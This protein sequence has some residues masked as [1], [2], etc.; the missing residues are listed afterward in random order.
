MRIRRGFTLIELLV[1]IAIIAVLIAL[2][3]PAVQSAREAARRSQCVNNLKQVGLALH[4]YESS[5][6][7]FPPPLIRTGRC[8]VPSTPTPT[9]P[10]NYQVMNHTGFAMILGQ[11]EQQALYNAMNFSHASSMSSPYSVAAAGTDAVNSTVTGTIV[12]AY[13]CPSDDPALT[14]SNLALSNDFYERNNVAR[15]NHLF[16]TGIYTDYTCGYSYPNV[17]SANKAPFFT[18]YSVR[19]AKSG[20]G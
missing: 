3:L 16:N 18:D 9:P 1:V 20:T 2:L 14:S 10:P 11:V 12:A 5:N 13:V 8:N 15:S 17:G 7:A 6:G 19:I 4:N